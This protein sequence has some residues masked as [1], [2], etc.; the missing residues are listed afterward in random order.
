MKKP[1]R[2]LLPSGMTLSLLAVF[3]TFQNCGNDSA[4]KEQVSEQSEE[5]AVTN[6]RIDD[7]KNIMAGLVDAEKLERIKADEDLSSQIS[8]LGKRIDTQESQLT[9]SLAGISSDISGLKAK[10]AELADRMGA[11][12]QSAKNLELTFELKITDVDATLRSSILNSANAVWAKLLGIDQNLSELRQSSNQNTKELIDQ[13]QAL[14]EIVESQ[15]LFEIYANETYA[16][17]MELTAQKQLYAALE[18][19]TKALDVRVTRTAQEIADTLGPR[20]LELSTKITSL[21]QKVS[22][23]QKDIEVLRS[24]LGSAIQEYRRQHQEYATL[25]RDEIAN[26]QASL[27]TLVVH[28]SNAVRSE[29]LTELNQRS[30][31]LTLYTNKSVSLIADA[32][33]TLS[34]RVDV[35]QDA[36]ATALADVRTQMMDA[37]G[38]EQVERKKLSDELASLIER[39]V[40]IET[41][42]SD[43]R[44]MTELNT[45]MISRISTDFEEE[46]AAVATRFSQ[47]QSVVDE[48]LR[49]LSQDLTQKLTDVASQAEQLV[50]NLGTE[51]QENFKSVALDIATLKNR[52]ATSEQQLKNFIEELQADRSRTISFTNRIAGPF[53]Q[54]QSQLVGIIDAL[55][56]LQL[57]FI[58][59]LN[60]D[61]ER[62]DFY[63]ESLRAMVAKLDK[64][65]GSLENT[66]FAN[67]LGMDSF[68]ILSVEYTHLLL[69]GLRSGGKDRDRM[70]HAFGAM[71][72]RGRLHQAVATGLVRTPFADGDAQCKYAVQ[73]WARGIILE[74]KRF[75]AFA[76]ALSED[77]EFERRLGVLYESYQYLGNPLQDIQQEIEAV[78]S[79]LKDREEAFASMINQTALDLINAA[80]DQRQLADRLAILEGF[81]TVQ[82]AQDDMRAEMKAGFASLKTKL[83]VF[84]EQTNQRLARLEEQNGKLS[85]SLKRALDVLITLSD[86]AGYPDLKAYAKWAGEPIGYTPVVYPNWQPRVS[87]VQHFFSGPLSLKN[88][89]AACTGAEILPKGGIQGYYQF[90][91]WGPCWVNFRTLPVATWGNE[92]KTLWI[93][94]FGAAHI[95]NLKVDP[96]TQKEN[97]AAFKNYNYDRKFDFR[98]DQADATIK[99]TGTFD[100]GVFDIQTPDLLDFYLRNI[101]T[102]GGV[103]LSVSSSRNEQIGGETIVTN[104]SI[105]KYTIQVFSPLIVDLQS[106]GWPRTIPPGKS[107]VRLNLLN[108]ERFEPTGW[109]S[110]TEAAFLLKTDLPIGAKITRDHLFIEQDRCRGMVASN[111]F[112]SLSCY[113]QDSNGQ[114]DR[115]DPAFRELRL[116]FDYDS[117]AV[118]DQGEIRTLSDVAI[119][120]LPLDYQTLSEAEGVR[121]GNDLRYFAE[122]PSIDG[123]RA[124]GKLIDVYLGVEGH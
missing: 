25:L 24:D 29:L 84:E 8:E 102:W 97:P 74:D 3:F 16:S 69:S 15:R 122:L 82:T 93:R 107:G 9:S 28:Q 58:Q 62:P 48:K 98:N 12:E 40:A 51:V 26:V 19:A 86:R 113:D 13:R 41:E 22:N 109:V 112:E 83:Q 67:V 18:A 116:F 89:T 92:F 76:E 91:G 115:R 103:T 75:D 23:Q 95:V 99:M 5:I 106:S 31:E 7:L 96:A 63:N 79:G 56:S 110:G 60:P 52:Q 85:L 50:K 78:V 118:V 54:G 43:L 37:I 42:I 100:N 117:D 35:A 1:K 87:M 27:G 38:S 59:V 2:W 94:V 111:G 47:Q 66:S 11:L 88:K 80:W 64:R 70:F 53:R 39:V 32:I 46:K 57:R 36:Q 33:S 72:R 77:E 121:D 123:N 20:V 6:L 90:G 21:E 120:Q 68:Q 119:A 71:A 81:E 17:K 34:K 45:T 105:F 4:V 61:D 101:R 30:L 65:C 49:L 124:R 114:V 44:R 14:V 104:S 108:P 55:S 73:Q 10:D